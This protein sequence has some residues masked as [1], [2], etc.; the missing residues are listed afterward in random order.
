MFQKSPQRFWVFIEDSE[1]QMVDVRLHFPVYISYGCLIVTATSESNI[2]TNTSP[3]LSENKTTWRK[4][5]HAPFCL[6]AYL[7]FSHSNFNTQ[8]RARTKHIHKHYLSFL[9]YPSPFFIN[10]IFILMNTFFVENHTFHSI[11]ASFFLYVLSILLFVTI[12]LWIC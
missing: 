2:I 7:L 1:L 5:R 3:L 10:F 6:V 12:L 4:N 9:A 11:S 8:T